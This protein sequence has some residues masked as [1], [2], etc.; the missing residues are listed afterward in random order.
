MTGIKY[1]INNF[2]NLV[3]L[4]VVSR[5]IP[6]L[7]SGY[8]IKYTGLHSFGKLEF[9]KILNYL[10]KLIIAYGFI[11]TI[12]RYFF[13]DKKSSDL[14]NE[15][16]D[17]KSKIPK[18]LGTILCIKSFLA[19][20]SFFLLLLVFYLVPSLKK[21]STVIFLFFI[22]AVCSG[23]APICIYQSIG[24]IHIITV[25]N[26][27]TKL[28]FYL[29]IPLY[30]KSEADLFY[31]PLAYCIFEFVRLLVYFFI[32]F[33]FYEIRISRPT[34]EDIIKQFKEGFSWFCFSFYMFFCNNF[35]ILFLKIYLGNIYVG[36]YKL[37]ANV[38]YICQQVLEPFIQ[39]LYPIVHKKFKNDIILG[40]KFSLKI[41]FYYL[42]L[43]SLV[44]LMCYI[45]SENIIYFFS[46]G[47]II[48][49]N[50]VLF[51]SSVSILRINILIYFLSVVS[52]FIGVQI[53][54]SI[55]YKYLYSMIVFLG[56][57]ISVC[58]HFILVRYFN[59]FGVIYSVLISE[60]FIFVTIIILFLFIFLIN[61]IKKIT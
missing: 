22:V 8:I 50:A 26:I 7:M 25:F 47:N 29:S 59:I 53:F 40:V 57:I 14:T 1:F 9:A 16:E 20:L 37:G 18:I 23:F 19:I 3:F 44:G 52:T 31:Y 58:L 24:K 10:F 51:K 60:I 6:V 43:F 46:G 41:L 5:V 48:L 34:F 54:S 42:S 49:D 15:N 33:Y 12:P 28:F 45:F 35:P 39:S 13:N 11:Y 55:G 61:G 27:L 38:I 4:R 36:V 21:D 17:L 30:I 56:G 2:S 32:L